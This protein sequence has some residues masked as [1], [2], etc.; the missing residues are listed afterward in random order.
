ML[1]K[2]VYAFSKNKINKTEIKKKTLK[3]P[4]I[5][6]NVSKKNHKQKFQNSKSTI[7]NH[8]HIVTSPMLAEVLCLMLEKYFIK[9][10]YNTA[11]AS[12]E[13]I[14]VSLTKAT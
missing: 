5:N 11:W 4:L 13:A 14:F 2:F 6:L 3:E 9:P 7:F 8:Y 1:I 10:V 12:D